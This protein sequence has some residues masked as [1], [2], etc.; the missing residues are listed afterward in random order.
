[1]KLITARDSRKKCNA[2]W[3]CGEVIFTGYR[4]SKHRRGKHLCEPCTERAEDELFWRLLLN[5]VG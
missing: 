1:M 4:H 5:K 3:G 2:P